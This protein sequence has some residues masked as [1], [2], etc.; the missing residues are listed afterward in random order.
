MTEKLEIYLVDEELTKEKNGSC[1]HEPWKTN[2]KN[3]K[4]KNNRK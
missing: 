4:L 1:L 3:L 2:K